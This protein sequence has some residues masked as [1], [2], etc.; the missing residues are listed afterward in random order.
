MDAAEARANLERAIVDALR[1]EEQIGAEDLVVDFVVMAA[2][3]TPNDATTYTWYR[4]A[5]QPLYRTVGL[6]TL[7]TRWLV[8]D[9]EDD[10]T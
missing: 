4:P 2:A 10:D 5:G 6:A 3:S 1:V 9:A 7:V 8:T